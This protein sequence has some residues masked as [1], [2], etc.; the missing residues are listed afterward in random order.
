MYFDF[1]IAYEHYMYES[2]AKVFLA[3]E[4]FGDWCKHLD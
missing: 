2:N 4:T 3:E 1:F